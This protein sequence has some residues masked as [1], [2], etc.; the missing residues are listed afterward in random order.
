MLCTGADGSA[1]HTMAG[2]LQEE[3]GVIVWACGYAANTSFRVLDNH[4]GVIKLKV[5]VCVCVGLTL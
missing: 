5:C 1:H 3:A 2:K 4:G